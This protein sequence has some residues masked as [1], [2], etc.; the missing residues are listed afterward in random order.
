MSWLI[1]KGVIE[2]VFLRS[3]VSDGHLRSREVGVFFVEF[4]DEIL[5][6]REVLNWF[7]CIVFSGV[8]FPV[9]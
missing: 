7:P 8:P 6:S 4:L 9:D 1:C 5:G 3:K 2:S